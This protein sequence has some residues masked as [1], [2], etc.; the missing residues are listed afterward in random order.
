MFGSGTI[1]VTVEAFTV[2]STHI[3][4]P[5]Q[6]SPWSAETAGKRDVTKAN[7]TNNSGSGTRAKES[8]ILSQSQEAR[9]GGNEGENNVVDGKARD[10]RPRHPAGRL[11]GLCSFS[12]LTNPR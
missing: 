10:G 3:K 8:C 9:T 1:H 11:G 6:E 2:A 4:V 12:C 5:H 7:N